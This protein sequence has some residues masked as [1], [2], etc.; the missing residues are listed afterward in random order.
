LIELC[1]DETAHVNR[2]ITPAVS[3]NDKAE[4]RM[5]PVSDRNY[6]C[7][8]PENVIYWGSTLAFW[9]MQGSNRFEVQI[10]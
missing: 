3:N 8:H 9:V 1:V 7:E 6:R 5:A 10:L 2:F 4:I